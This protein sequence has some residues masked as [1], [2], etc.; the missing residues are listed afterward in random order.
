MQKIDGTTIRL[1]RG[2]ELDLSLSLETDSGT[3]YEFEQGDLII[4]SLYNKGKMDDKALLIK[5]ITAT[6]GETSI[7]IS[8]TSTE[9]KI[10]NLINKPVEYWYEIEL[11]NRYTVVG[12]D[13]T[14]AKILMLYPEGSQIEE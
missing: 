10:G 6:G 14:G 12:Y 2:D 1:N 4:F 7:D 13:E 11:N 3:T 5:E 9:T 8:F